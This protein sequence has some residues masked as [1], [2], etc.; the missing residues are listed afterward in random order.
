[1]MKVLFTLFVALF[2]GVECQSWVPTA[3]TVATTP[4]PFCPPTGVEHR[5]TDH[6]QFFI[7][8]I[9]GQEHLGLCPDGFLFCAVHNECRPAAVVDCGD[10]QRP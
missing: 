6:C 5:P 9:N 8:C 7:I 4:Q 1:M 3:P 10:R 2:I